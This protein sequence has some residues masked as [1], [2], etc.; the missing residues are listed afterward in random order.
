[1]LV[2]EFKINLMEDGKSNCIIQSYVRDISGFL[3]YIS[4]MG[5]E[6]D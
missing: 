5:I 1:M 2:E 6:F 4:R 3:K